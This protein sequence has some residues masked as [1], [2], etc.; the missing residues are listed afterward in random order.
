MPRL[1]PVMEKQAPPQT[2][3]E[4][5]DLKL[6]EKPT[7]E[8]GD[9]PEVE[10][11][12]A[13][14]ESE[15]EI[16][17]KKQIEAL[18]QSEELQRRQAAQLMQ[19]RE[20]ALQ[21]A[22]EKEKRLNKFE[23]EIIDQEE[24]A[25]K[26]AIAAAKA[27]ADKALA[28]IRTAKNSGDIE[29]EIEATDRL[30]DAK[31]NLSVL[32]RGRE[33]VDIKRKER[34]KERR[35]LEEQQETQSSQQQQPGVQY[36][37]HVVEW[38]NGHPEFFN[39]PRNNAR[40]QLAFYDSRDEGYEPYSKAQIERIEELVGVKK[41]NQQEQKTNERASIMSAP[42]SREAPSG[43]RSSSKITLTKDEKEAARIAGVTEVEY[44]KNKQRLAE[45][46]ADGTYGDQR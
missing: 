28:D 30:T 37:P 23:K 26:A 45:M 18:R 8:P 27:E 22:K 10:V 9:E 3:A 19:E 14:K 46:R 40:L 6:A 43:S 24:V 20:K 16:A 35:K 41:N 29:A 5:L 11:V 12:D 13:P 32:K 1:R 21:E 7:V 25:I 44:A 2:P 34:K 17:L 39:D 36:P 31:A 38:I 42:V 4:E 33:E 15:A